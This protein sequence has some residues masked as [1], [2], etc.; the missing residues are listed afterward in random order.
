MYFCPP[1]GGWL[2]VGVPYFFSSACSTLAMVGIAPSLEP[3]LARQ[4]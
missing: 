2:R 1:P 3:F 4:R